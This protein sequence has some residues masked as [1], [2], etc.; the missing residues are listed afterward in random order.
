M[1]YLDEDWIDKVRVEIYEETKHMS[2]DELHE[3]FR[4]YSEE[5]SK[6][7]GFTFVQPLISNKDE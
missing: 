3:Y 1:T 4:K 6:K 5:A 7:Y 2:N